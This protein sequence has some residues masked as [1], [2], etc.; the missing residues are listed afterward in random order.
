MQLLHAS[1][2]SRL[3]TLLRG[4][5]FSALV[6][7]PLTAQISPPEGTLGDKA[8]FTELGGGEQL[9]RA[10]VAGATGP[11]LTQDFDNTT[12]VAGSHELDAGQI[13]LSS[14]RH[15]VL[16]DTRFDA[17]AGANRAEVQTALNLAGT[18]LVAGRSQ[19]YIRR[20]AGA[21]EAVLSG[22]AI[23]SV[24]TSGDVLTLESWRTDTNAN[25]AVL[26]T[27]IGGGTAVQLMRLDDDWDFLNL[28]LGANQ[29]G[30]IGTAEATVAYDT[31]ASPGTTGTAFSVAGGDVTLNESGLYLV[32]ANTSL[33]KATNA[34]RT[35][36]LQ[37][38][39][40]DGSPV[41]GSTTTTYVRGSEDGNEGMTS[42]GMVLSAT[43]GQVLNVKVVMDVAGSST[44]VIQG[45]ETALTMVKLPATAEYISLIDTS[46]QEVND[47]ALDP[48]VFN[49]QVGASSASFS[50]TEGGS[51]VT[52][53]E[54]ADY[55]FFGSIFTQSDATNDNQD[56]TVPLQGWQID[57]V[58][59]RIDRG[60]GAQYNRDNGGARAAGSWGAA[61]IPL[62]AAQT[63]QLTTA[64]IAHTD[65][66]LQTSV[67]GLQ[68][69]S[70]KSL[71]PSVD[72]IVVTNSQLSLVVNT[73][74]T[75]DGSLLSAVDADD[76]P[77]AIFYT[78]SSEPTLGILKNGVTVLGNGDTFTQQ[79]L[80][81]DAITFEAGAGTGSGGFDFVVFDDS[82]SLVISEGSFV[83]GVGVPTLLADDAASTDEDTVI[84]EVAPGVLDNDAGTS[85]AVTSF[86]ALSQQGAVVNV[87]SDGA[88]TY[89]PTAALALQALDDGDSVVDTFNYT[90]T[91]Y[92][93]AT[94][95]AKVDV[96]VNGVNDAPLV[97]DDSASGTDVSGPSLNVLANDSDI[98]ANDTITVVSLDGN[99]VGLGGLTI[100]SGEEA[101]ISIDPEGNFVY[102]P[103]T[104][105]DIGALPNGSSMIDT[106]AYE[107]F[108]GT[109]TIAGTISITSTGSIG[110]SNDIGI[111]A[112]NGTSSIDVLFNDDLLGAA[113]TPTAGAVTD[114]NASDVGNT[115]TTWINNGTGV[116]GLDI[117]MENPGVQS[118]LNTGLSGAPVGV[119][120][121]YDLSGTSSGSVIAATDV[122]PNIYGVN[123]S[124]T[125]VTV[126]MVFRPDDLVGPEPLWGSG[127]NGTG[128]SLV[129]LDD[130]L[131]FTAGQGSIVAQAVGTLSNADF[132]HVLASL[133][134]G[135]DT[136]S[137]YIDGVL[138]GSGTAIN[139]TTGAAADI[140]DWSGTDSEGVGRS[141]GTTGGDINIAPFLGAFGNGGY[142]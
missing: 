10:T 90:V 132:V 69:L 135:T 75:I 125:S 70:C 58:G 37:W 115:D 110:A 113:G 23:V 29:V 105:A 134:L 3:R 28:E 91:D 123:I 104:S 11:V 111:V 71:I 129:L 106:I 118:V 34:T 142:S 141:N 56:R 72:P 47:A 119:T 24:A 57:G 100:L 95:S 122:I 21:D 86:E 20:T 17:T 44:G 63:V 67:A 83:V 27:R 81:D 61:I 7:T 133:D 103:S 130:Q 45:G 124:A 99:P 25:A 26:P 138:A 22:G 96:T 1:K 65:V 79:D 50:H 85:L 116:G 12:L 92:S 38:L 97:V 82:G 98:D 33:Q 48:V 139:I 117:T 121:A 30:A 68:A 40:L 36:Y 108:D 52:V 114:F 102:D 46:N 64:R 54:D 39:A 13:K 131:I 16:Y 43:A 35:N 137:L 31:N 66:G 76:G 93:F 49:T 15:L 41:A 6:I 53:N 42:L 89:D 87:G 84:S 77:E 128:S 60:R 5:A 14:G 120:A 94:T 4:S 62:T 107:V 140:T 51:A 136:A 19:G 32:F 80:N 78:L 9:T 127:G 126:E 2:F 8:V 59:G 109:V 73:T 74:G 18:R 112:A 88:Y 101:T 55:L